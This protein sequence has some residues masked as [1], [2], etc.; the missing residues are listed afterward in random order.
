MKNKLSHDEAVNEVYRLTPQIRDYDE[1]MY[2]GVRWLPYTMFFHQTNFKSK[3]INTDSLGFRY[4]KYKDGYIS[5]DSIPSDVPINIIIGGSTTLGTGATA[6]EYTI[7]SGLSKL[8]GE[9]W[10]NFGGR[11]YN[12]TQEVILFLM[13]QQ[14][15]NQIN[16]VVVFSGMNTLTLEGIPDELATE[17]GRYYYSYEYQYYMN[18]YN[19]DL[20]RRANSYASELDNRKLNPMKKLYNKIMNVSDGFNPA[21]VIITD[22]STDTSQRLIR[23]A[24]V[25]EQTMSQWK[26]LLAPYNS[27]L[28]FFLQPMSYWSKTQLT[29]IEEEIFCAIDQCPNN[30]WRL[31]SRILAKENHP[32]LVNELRSRLARLNINFF[33]MNI[34]M[35]ESPLINESIY[36]DRVHFNDEGY[37]EMARLINK[38]IGVNHE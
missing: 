7:A 14:R 33:D 6:D 25:I 12:S 21:D 18:K 34:I 27:K 26:S 22:E 36:V 17:H 2:L 3:T 20:K 35:G 11:G 16:H 10:I 4:T 28:S 29:A 30:F 8:T 23:T 13:H 9:P 38:Y 15:F 1:F 31:F 19:D 32:I 5:M 24:T 37:L